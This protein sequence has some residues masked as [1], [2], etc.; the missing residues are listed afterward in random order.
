M[1]SDQWRGAADSA[2]VALIFTAG[3]T[4]LRAQQPECS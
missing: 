3:A 4:T 1:L 2:G